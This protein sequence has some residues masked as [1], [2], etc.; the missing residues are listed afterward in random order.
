MTTKDDEPPDTPGN[1]GSG[2]AL[3]P[4]DIAALDKL[5][6]MVDEH[7]RQARE[8]SPGDPAPTPEKYDLAAISESYLPALRPAIRSL[9]VEE[10]QRLQER[11]S[12]IPLHTERARRSGGASWLD[13]AISYGPAS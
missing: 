2:D 13:L 7:L 8:A 9:V 6:R 11:L 1:D 10:A 4:E 12:C 3:T 5:D